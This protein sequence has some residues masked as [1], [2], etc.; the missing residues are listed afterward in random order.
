MTSTRFS[1]CLLPAGSRWL[2][3]ARDSGGKRQQDSVRQQQHEYEDWLS[4]NGQVLAQHYQ[5]IARPGKTMVGRVGLDGLLRDSAR[6]PRPADGVLFWSI[7]RSG[8]DLND[9]DYIKA[10]LR[11]R[12]YSVVFLSN[13]IPQDSSGVSHI[14]EAAYA[15]KAQ[16][17]SK[18]MG[19]DIRR[20]R[21]DLITATD[22]TGAYCRYWLGRAGVGF[23]LERIQIGN[24]RNGDPHIVSRLEIDEAAAAVVLQAFEMRRDRMSYRS[25]RDATGLFA[26]LRYTGASSFKVMFRNT[27]Y[28][29]ALTYE[30]EAHE[31]FIT[32]IVERELWEAVQ[33]VNADR[34]ERLLGQRPA[35]IGSRYL[36]SG[37]LRCGLCD[38]ALGGCEMRASGRVYTYYRHFAHSD[39]ND[40]RFH[41]VHMLDGLIV[42]RVLNDALSPAAVEAMVVAANNEREAMVSGA[43]LV[44]SDLESRILGTEKAI[45]NLVA[46]ARLSP[47]SAALGRELVALEST[48]EGL[49][50]KRV[51]AQAKAV[52]PL[53]I[54]AADARASKLRALLLG[55]DVQAARNALSIVVQV[56][57]LCGRDIEITY[58]DWA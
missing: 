22:S 52:K 43:S 51:E 32:A 39:C 1:P 24:H 14:L 7:N 48:L 17:D 41:R 26:D 21:R 27:L 46:S 53:D 3:Y 18:Q 16:N 50:Q 15:W 9:I 57:T 36:L 33:T 10:D 20:G 11:R 5:D 44:L 38:E 30:G 6:K 19:A 8:R 35:N 12:G 31:N 56:I 23:K 37:L 45:M 28:Y 2:T 40:T 29:G 34:R 58:K 4:E 49:Q 55:S 25:I 13:D 54:K 42:E 47:L